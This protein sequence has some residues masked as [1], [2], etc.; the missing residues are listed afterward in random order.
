MAEERLYIKLILPK[1]GTDKKVPGGS[2][3][4]EPFKEINESFTNKLIQTLDNAAQTL[5]TE[6]S[7]LKI[8]PLQV[9]LENKAV[10]KSH[11]PIELFNGKTCPIIGVGKL[12]ELFL[13]GTPQGINSLKTK[14]KRLNS[15]RL[16]KAVSTIKEMDVVS[17]ERKMIGYDVK[18]LFEISPVVKGEKTVKVSL[19]DYRDD[20]ENQLKDRDF[21]TYLQNNSVN[22]E[23]C[24]QYRNRDIYKVQIKNEKEVAIITKALMVREVSPLP[25]FK[26]IKS[27]HLA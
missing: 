12:G 16:K 23:K 4:V 14:I 11:R 3:K 17:A 9:L 20:T 1:Q 10:A 7:K 8:I 26:A 5:K 27:M 15:K 18:E 13:K 21:E 19:F 6:S 2:G 22:F 25:T 24:S